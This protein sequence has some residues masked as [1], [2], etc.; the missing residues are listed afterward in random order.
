MDTSHLSSTVPTIPDGSTT[1]LCQTILYDLISLEGQSLVTSCDITSRHMELF[2]FSRQC[3]QHCLFYLCELT[4]LI[5]IYSFQVHFI[6]TIR[7]QIRLTKIVFLMFGNIL[8][9][10]KYH[11]GKVHSCVRYVIQAAALC[12]I[13]DSHKV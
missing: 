9:K 3:S 2:T 4:G 11:T 6:I 13:S 12:Q 8:R 10:K 1:L 7:S 5:C